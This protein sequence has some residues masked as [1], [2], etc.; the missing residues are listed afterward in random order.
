MSRKLIGRGLAV[1]ALAAGLMVLAVQA[2]NADHTALVPNEPNSGAV[3]SATATPESGTVDMSK[4]Q[5]TRD[6]ILGG[7]SKFRPLP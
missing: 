1:F 7:G 3:A 5:L 4:W 2:T 6:P